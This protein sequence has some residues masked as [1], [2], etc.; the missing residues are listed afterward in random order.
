MATIVE[1]RG[2][3]RALNAYPRKIIKV[4]AYREAVDDLFATLPAA[5]WA[6]TLA[7][8]KSGTTVRKSL[9]GPP[10]ARS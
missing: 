5:E 1:Y 4:E 7:G 10:A 3:K 9:L 8:G 2:Y 6:R